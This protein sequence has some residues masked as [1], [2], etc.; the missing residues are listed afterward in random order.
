MKRTGWHTNRA[1]AQRVS[2]RFEKSGLSPRDFAIRGDTRADVLYVA[3]RRRAGTG[4]AGR[5]YRA[6]RGRSLG[7]SRER[8]AEHVAVLFYRGEG[9]GRLPRNRHPLARRDVAGRCGTHQR[10]DSLGGRKRVFCQWVTI[11]LQWRLQHDR[12][13]RAGPVNGECVRF[14]QRPPG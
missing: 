1:G 3:E 9:G 14:N 4:A 12:V 6:V 2:C 7:P 5:W 8:A 10:N 13:R 11:A